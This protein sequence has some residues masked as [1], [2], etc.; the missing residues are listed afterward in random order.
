M[1]KKPGQISEGAYGKVSLV[2]RDG[3]KYV[4]KKAKTFDDHQKTQTNFINLEKEFKLLKEIEDCEHV[5]KVFNFS[6]DKTKYSEYLAQYGEGKSL[7]SYLLEHSITFEQCL[8]YAL[9]LVKAVKCFHMKHIYHLDIKTQNI[10]FLDKDH[11]ELAFIDFGL[12]KKSLNDRCDFF[13]NECEYMAPEV[14]KPTYDRK[15]IYS[16]SKSDIYSLGI[17]FEELYKK[18]DSDKKDFIYLYNFMSDSNPEIRPTIDQIESVLKYMNEK[19]KLNLHN[20][21]YIK[22]EF[23]F[24]D[25]KKFKKFV[26]QLIEQI[27]DFH[28]KHKYVNINSNNISMDKDQNLYILPKFS[29]LTEKEVIKSLGFVFEEL[30]KK[31]I[32]GFDAKQKFHDLIKRMKNA[33]ISIDDIY[34]HILKYEQEDKEEE[35]EKEKGNKWCKRDGACSLMFKKSKKKNK[36]SKSKKKSKI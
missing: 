18:Q 29:D 34:Q 22:N 14:I 9:Q 19:N 25:E 6:T 16:C 26:K 12:G 4:L 24:I 30:Y 3:K 23:T 2:E 7:Y 27:N 36:K 11:K 10:V 5:I 32:L 1:S 35:D 13:C 21:M 17:V 33:E 31:S 20:F 15:N 8:G 28:K